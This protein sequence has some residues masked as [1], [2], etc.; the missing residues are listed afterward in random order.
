[1]VLAA[2]SGGGVGVGLTAPRQAK[3]DR[4]LQRLRHDGSCDR[5]APLLEAGEVL[6]EQYVGDIV[7]KTGECGPIARGA[8][9]IAA[10]QKVLHTFFFELGLDA[11]RQ[12]KAADAFQ[13][14]RFSND[15]GD[16]SRTNSLA[17]QALA[18][19]I[20]RTKPVAGGDPLEG[21]CAPVVEAVPGE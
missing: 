11:V 3:A 6:L 4:L 17:A 2:L 1:M 12:D 5:M 10:T 20:S 13:C 21:F 9:H 16:R 15:C 18:V 7:E 19:Q 14:F 8:L